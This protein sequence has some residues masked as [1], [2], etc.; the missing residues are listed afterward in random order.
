MTYYNNIHMIPYFKYHTSWF[1]CSYTKIHLRT[2]NSHSHGG[3]VLASINRLLPV[4]RR[5]EAAG[6]AED[7]VGAPAGDQD[8]VHLARRQTV[9]GWPSA[10][11]EP[12]HTPSLRSRNPN[13]IPSVPLELF[14]CTNTKNICVHGKYICTVPCKCIFAHTNVFCVRG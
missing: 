7:E 12:G 5:D 14:L 13:S 3:S 11:P 10:C 8:R 9:G 1:L 4:P 6:T 2:Q